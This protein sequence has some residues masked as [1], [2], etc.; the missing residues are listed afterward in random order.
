[1]L[2]EALANNYLPVDESK[3]IHRSGKKVLTTP[4]VLPTIS[5]RDKPVVL[6]VPG[7]NMQHLKETASIADIKADS[8]TQAAKIK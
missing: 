6:R 3:V 2:D 8:D 5:A 7:L 1:M 4:Q